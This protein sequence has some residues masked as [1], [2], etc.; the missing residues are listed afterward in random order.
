VRQ[1]SASDC[2]SGNPTAR[3]RLHRV[4][5]TNFIEQKAFKKLKTFHYIYF[6]KPHDAIVRQ[7]R[8]QQQ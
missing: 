5:F 1:R 2:F 8:E 3:A 7:R 4:P 6:I